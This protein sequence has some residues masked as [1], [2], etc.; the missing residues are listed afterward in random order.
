MKLFSHW[1]IATKLILIN[2]MVFLI[3]G[4]GMFVVFFSFSNIERM[5]TRIVK[6][7]VYQVI[8]NARI[9]R[10]LTGVFADTSHL[11]DRFLEQEDLLKNEGDRLVK[12]TNALDTQ[13][14]NVRLQEA[15][16]E[17][18][19]QLQALLEQGTIISKV[20]Q[21]LNTIDQELTLKLKDL[22]SLIANTIIVVRMESR[23]TSSL[24]RLSLNVPWYREALLR[25]NISLYR[26][27]QK[28]LRIASKEEE[29]GKSILQL[30]VLLDELDAKLQS[31][32]SS[33]PNVKEFGQQFI[34]TVRSYKETIAAFYKELTA[35][36]Q[37]LDAMNN[38]Q[39]AVLTVLEEIDAQIVET[40]GYIQENATGVMQSARRLIIILSGVIM[41]AT[42]FGWLGIRWMVKPL[43]HLSRVADQLADGDIECHIAD[44]RARDE[45]GTL[46]RAFRRLILYFQ[47]MAQTVIEISQGNLE[48]EVMAKSKQDVLR[49]GFQ[50]MILYLK[51]M[52]KFATHAARGDLRH[53]IVL[54]SQT[55]Q[56]GNA[57]V[58]M[59]EGLIALIAEIRSGADY[60]ASISSQVL[61]TSLKNTEI[62]E[63]IAHTAE[64]TS[65]AMQE[66]SA[67]AG[68]VRM[69]TEDLTSSVEE[70]SASINQMLAS[71][72]HVAE[73]SRKL[74]G[75]AA[76]TSVTMT[77][78]VNSFEKIA[79]QAEHSKTLAETTTQDVVF[80]QK[81]MMQMMIRMTAISE[82]T[83]GISQIISQLENRSRE[84]GTILDVI[85]EVA[86]QTSLLALNASIIA[87]QAGVHGRGFAVVANEI[88]ELATRVATSTKKIAEIIKSVQGDSAD[89]A[90]AI[91]QGQ[92]EVKNGVMIARQAEKA[93]Q[94]IEQS[95]KNS[96]GVAAEIAILVRQQTTASTQV[97]ESI[98]DVAN[99]VSEITRAT[100][101]QEKKV[102]VSCT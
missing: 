84:I 28:H 96:A 97:A 98:H 83:E 87:A 63:Q 100:Q 80:G 69:T 15:L 75:F 92:R 47:E 76:D 51:E 54:R 40:T 12:T 10:E 86:D 9:G 5:M 21:E 55:D 44:A 1:S 35:F 72:T 53:Q 27:I 23:D 46:S 58:H 93:L 70:T 6:Q 48:L 73:N 17:F 14:T 30:L 49:N 45:I 2:L 90:K 31:L 57:F 101:E 94:K 24:E 71:I 18:T 42:V 16:Q 88:K 19:R 52:G 29:A 89:A 8:E 3:I 95:T 78:M 34:D 41:V 64:V 32:T 74:S 59:R 4:G 37:Q 11:L 60:I 85:N 77:A 65:S 13:R 102:V 67:S 7:D 66:V 56:L 99:M 50:Q 20:S 82:V 43:L 39:R 25:V 61:S 81:S 33:E 38:A 79:D 91:G 68:E 26:V 22:E 62:L 36:Q